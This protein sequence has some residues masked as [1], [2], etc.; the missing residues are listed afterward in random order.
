M[1]ESPD[2]ALSR[3]HE[4]M[5]SM[6][7]PFPRP[8]L[9]DRSKKEEVGSSSPKAVPL[10]LPKAGSKAKPGY[11]FSKGM[12]K[13]LKGKTPF[14]DP[15]FHPHPQRGRGKG[16]AKL[17]PSPSPS[18]SPSPKGK[19]KGKG[20]GDAMVKLKPTLP[21]EW[22]GSSLFPP[23]ESKDP[24]MAQGSETGWTRLDRIEIGIASPEQIRGWAERMLS[25]ESVVGKVE[26]PDT[27][28]YKTHRPIRDGLFC[29]RIFG[30]VSSHRCGCGRRWS[31]PPLIPPSSSPSF[32]PP[33]WKVLRVCPLCE[34]EPT[35]SWVRRSRLGYIELFSGVAHLWHW[36][37]RSSHITDLVG[38]ARR[39]WL[40]R[41]VKCNTFL[42]QPVDGAEEPIQL[43]RRRSPS[44]PLRRTASVS[45]SPKVKASASLF[46]FLFPDGDGEEKKR[47]DVSFST[48][49]FTEE[50][51]EKKK[52]SSL[53]KGGPSVKRRQARRVRKGGRYFQCQTFPCRPIVTCSHTYRGAFR[54]FLV[55]PATREDRPLLHHRRAKPSLSPSFPPSPLEMEMGKGMASASLMASPTASLHQTT[56][57]PLWLKNTFS[58]LLAIHPMNREESAQEV[59]RQTGG[60]AIQHLL[61]KVD[62]TVLRRNLKHR[63]L[64]LERLLFDLDRRRQKMKRVVKNVK[65]ERELVIRR[66]KVVHSFL[67]SRRRPEWMVLSNLPVLPPDLR[68]IIRT[69]DGVIAASDLNR[70]YQR[71]LYANRGLRRLSIVNPN[72]ISLAKRSLQEAVDALI[73]NG[74][75]GGKAVLDHTTGQPLKSI[76][77][78][79]KGKKGRFR[80]HLLGKR[81]DYSGRSVIIVGPTLHLHQ[82]GLPR[83][84]AIELFHPFLIRYL[85]VHRR[86]TNVATAKRYIDQHRRVIWKILEQVIGHHPVLLNRAPTL[87]RLG[88]QAFQPMLVQGRAI[89]LHPL[90]C[91]GF[92]A[93]FDGD[94]MGVHIPLSFQARAEAWRL[95]WSVNNLLSPATGQP[96]V[97]PTQDMVLGCYYIT[98]LDEKMAFQNLA[99]SVSP[100]HAESPKLKPSPSPLA[101]GMRKGLY[102]ANLQDALGAHTAG[103]IALHTPLWVRFA[104][105]FESQTNSEEPLEVRIHVDGR[106]LSIRSEVQQMTSTRRGRSRLV[107]RYIRTTAGRIAMHDIIQP[108]RRRG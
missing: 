40:E 2:T 4:K 92:N 74:K 103:H 46:P 18:R 84:M 67:A 77:A 59:L 21:P 73:E 79:L 80:H 72:T 51:S 56:R 101:M 69:P 66:I 33:K 48:T 81:V 49:L 55:E 63:L 108:G 50:W 87:H 42:L 86:A 107:G 44:H 27:V 37:G 104:G 98:S 82:C 24:S 45:S 95:L 10:I 19:G 35:S 61:R 29:E 60:E 96:I 97:V 100:K 70:L 1:S 47:R 8:D 52:F 7:P 62:L 89:H 105:K 91:T 17:K 15:P 57:S 22:R 26:N 53:L 85:Q 28:E 106:Q 41:L 30:P 102:F 38:I 25:T 12:L 64:D 14:F 32:F 54:A 93:D 83:E 16:T 71:I 75:G 99:A 6:K 5:P 36:R 3:Q 23:L 90:V 11:P 58:N 39:S 9:R 13:Q 43:L 34:V 76:S 68:P 94:Q 78:S 31:S 88:I 20:K 65:R